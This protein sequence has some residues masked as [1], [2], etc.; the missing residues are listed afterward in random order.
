MKHLSFLKLAVICFV[1][2]WIC[3]S[4]VDASAEDQNQ[5]LQKRIEELS[6]K[7]EQTNDPVELMKIMQDLQDIMQQMPAPVGGMGSEIG[8]RQ[9]PG[10]TSRP[11]C[12]SH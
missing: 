8:S 12:G 2:A 10:G 7:V 11:G 6:K 4:P 3:V 9:D 1:F 5:E